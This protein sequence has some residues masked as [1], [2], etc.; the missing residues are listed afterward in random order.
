M[1]VASEI[2]KAFISVSKDA[3]ATTIFDATDVARSLY[4]C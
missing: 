2:D 3:I 4:L 1:N